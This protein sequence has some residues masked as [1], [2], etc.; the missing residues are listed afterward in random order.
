[1]G[2]YSSNSRRQAAPPRNAVPPLLRGIGCITFVIIPVLSY[3][4]ADYCIGKIPQVASLFQSNP[5]LMDRVTI[6]PLLFQLRGL[7]RFWLFLEQ[8]DHLGANLIL[9]IAL[10]MIIGGLMAIVYGYIYAMFGPSRFG[11]TDVPP[12]RVKTK[13]YKR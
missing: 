5:A 2:K 11:P 7:Q 10:I 12:P 4:I 1:M 3:A 6:N 9:T 8:Q 13:A